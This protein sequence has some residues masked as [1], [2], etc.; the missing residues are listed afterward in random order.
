LEGLPETDEEEDNAKRI[1]PIMSSFFIFFEE[2]ETATEGPHAPTVEETCP[3]GAKLGQTVVVETPSATIEAEDKG[4]S[5]P[6][7]S[8]KGKG[9]AKIEEAKK[10]IEDVRAVEEARGSCGARQAAARRMRHGGETVAEAEEARMTGQ[11]G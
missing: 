7:L 8:R 2:H 5:K 10:A 1:A 3:I 4:S 9:P 11:R 6:T